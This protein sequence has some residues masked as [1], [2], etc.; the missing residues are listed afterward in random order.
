MNI[1]QAMK[2]LKSGNP[3]HRR[4]MCNIIWAQL[5]NEALDLKLYGMKD[6]SYREPWSGHWSETAQ[7]SIEDIEATDWEVYVPTKAD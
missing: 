5:I 1:Y 4:S 7:F 3:I 6:L 2:I